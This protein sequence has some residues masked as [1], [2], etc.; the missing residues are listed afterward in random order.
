MSKIP[1]YDI[2][3]QHNHILGTISPQWMSKL[4]YNRWSSD[5]MVTNHRYGLSQ[6]EPERRYGILWPF[7]ALSGSLSGSLWPSVTLFLALSCS[8]SRNRSDSLVIEW[9]TDCLSGRMSKSQFCWASSLFLTSSSIPGV[10]S[11]EFY[12]LGFW[13]LHRRLSHCQHC[14]PWSTP[15]CCWM[16]SDPI[17]QIH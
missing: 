10:F 3:M 17:F 7:L 12:C 6:I 9:S 1:T 14:I 15:R 5:G 13:S 4:V 8:L 2:P 16:K 11:G